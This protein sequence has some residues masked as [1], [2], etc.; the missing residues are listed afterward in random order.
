VDVGD[1]KTD[2]GEGA[3]AALGS[4]AHSVFDL[5]SADAADVP[6]DVGDSDGGRSDA[7]NID[8]EDL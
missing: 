2:V 6:E 4:T 5:E 1:A 3:V 7:G 8:D